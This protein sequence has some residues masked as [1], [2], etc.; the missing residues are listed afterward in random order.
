MEAKQDVIDAPLHPIVRLPEPYYDKDGITIYH[1]DAVMILEAMP[2][3]TIDVIVT[4]P[5]YGTRTNQR[6]EWM[7]GEFSNVMPICI[8]Q[9]RRVTVP[10]GACYV[11]TSWMNIAD[12]IYRLS[13]HFKMQNLIA[14]DKGR[15][16]GCYGKYSWQFCWEAVYFGI[17]GPREVR[18]Y[19]P[20]V[21]RGQHA[22]TQAMEKPVGVCESLIAASTDEGQLV[23]DCFMG[24]GPTLIAARN[25]GRR[26]I[27]IEIDESLCE[28]AAKRLAQ[29]MLF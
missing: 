4:D 24:T 27:G 11:F 17:K 5:P 26:A 2:S 19:M 25:T 29:G 8:P 20:D 3:G 13:P 14:W 18:Q 10:N 6:D 15:H 1:G 9:W 23:L 12:W 22:P 28:K 16:S 21:I 7:A